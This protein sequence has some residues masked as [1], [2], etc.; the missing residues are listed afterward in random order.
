MKYGYC[1]VS[2]YK[3]LKDGNSIEDQ[4]EKLIE[5]G[6]EKIVVDYGADAGKTL[7]YLNKSKPGSMEYHA[8]CSKNNLIKAGA[9]V[10]IAEKKK[11]E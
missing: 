9:I 11:S 1:R 2:T 7:G 6:A 10:L 8:S 3:Q 5:A 4:R